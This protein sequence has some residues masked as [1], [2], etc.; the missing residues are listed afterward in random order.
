MSAH[1][2][3]AVVQRVIEDIFNQGQVA[4]FDELYASSFVDTP[5]WPDPRRPRSMPALEGREL[6]KAGDAMLRAAMPDLRTTIEA[7]VAEGD[8]VMVCTSTRG[9]HTGRP[10]FDVPATGR[11]LR[12]T[13]F[14]LYRL[15]EGK[16][17]E[18]RYLW[19]RLGVFQQLG[20]LPN[21]DEM[22]NMLSGQP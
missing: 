15:A 21:Q 8:T 9:T 1:E 14:A 12:W 3:K 18:E 4:L 10:F 19:D 13:S 6:I 11:E 2:N 22:Q 17:V 7:I 5:L 20:V 16:I